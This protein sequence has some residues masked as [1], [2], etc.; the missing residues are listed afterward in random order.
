[1]ISLFVRWDL[2][3]LATM[4]LLNNVIALRTSEFI[5]VKQYAFQAFL[6]IRVSRRIF[7]FYLV[8]PLLPTFLMPLILPLTLQ[9]SISTSLS[10]G[11][12]F[13][14]N[15]LVTYIISVQLGSVQVL[16]PVLLSYLYI[17]PYLLLCSPLFHPWPSVS[18]ILSGSLLA[19][20]CPGPVASS[21]FDLF[22]LLACPALPR[23]NF[24]V[25]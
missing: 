21:A 7:Q 23:P 14:K 15:L 2:Q 3:R 6:W 13:L 19:H 22:P 17:L 8:Y 5:L 16:N 20:I 1:M 18:H 25:I 11:L 4:E 10:V 12:C 24:V 9:H